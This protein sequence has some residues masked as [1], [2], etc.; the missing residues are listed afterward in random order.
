MTKS[1]R[2]KLNRLFATIIKDGIVWRKST[3]IAAIFGGKRVVHDIFLSLHDAWIDYMEGED[4]EQWG[5]EVP[6]LHFRR[7]GTWLG[8]AM[9]L[10]GR[11]L[12]CATPPRRGGWIEV[13]REDR[14][15]SK[16]GTA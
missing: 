4:L 3:D 8:V 12:P 9:P 5:W 13:Y 16:F 1:Q 14:L 11:W 15:R 10:D 7:D 2:R 6:I